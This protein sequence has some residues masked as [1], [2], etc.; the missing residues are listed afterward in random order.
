MK[1]KYNQDIEELMNAV[2]DGQATQRQQTELK[3]LMLHDI[4]I[5]EKLARMQRQKQILN[6]LPVEPAPAQLAQDIRAALERRLILENFTS[7]QQYAPVAHFKRFAAA[8]AML[9]LPLGLLALVVFQI[10]K[11]PSGEPVQ[12]ERTADVID[13]TTTPAPAVAAAPAA[14]QLP[15]NGILTF[16]TDQVAAV[17]TFVEKMIFDQGLINAS[18]PVRTADMAAYQVKTSPQNMIALVDSLAETW[19]RSSDVLLTVAVGPD[20]ETV[21]IANVKIEQLKTL[22]V[23]DST[24]M[25]SRLAARYAAANKNA[26]TFYANKTPDEQVGADN[27]PPLNRPILTGR[28]DPQVSQSDAP[29]IQLRIVIQR[30]SEP[31]Q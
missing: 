10:I 15:F 22:A 17:S 3:R 4:S 14:V 7:H 23:E 26:Q 20:S 29:A 16:K 30:P 18:M 13:R 31:R 11:P 2:V 19:V 12:Y 8:A 24:T 9:L 27:Y 6:A 1:D 28:Y 25:F 21:E 5:S